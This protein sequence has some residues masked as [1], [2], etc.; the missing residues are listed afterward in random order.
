METSKTV[1]TTSKSPPRERIALA[2]IA[3]AA[4]A[5][6]TYAMQRV[7]EV[8]RSG[9]HDPSLILVSSHVDYLWRILIATW[10]GGACALFVYARSSTRAASHARRWARVAL[11]LSAVVVVASVAWP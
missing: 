4:T 7:V 6:I 11:A 5:P 10:W 3:F 1:T 2:A 8:A 9:R